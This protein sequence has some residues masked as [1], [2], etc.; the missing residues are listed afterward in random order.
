MVC[1]RQNPC[2]KSCVASPMIAIVV[3]Q[4]LMVARHENDRLGGHEL[5][6]ST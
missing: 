1:P 4:P 5:P 2:E 3:P 6:I